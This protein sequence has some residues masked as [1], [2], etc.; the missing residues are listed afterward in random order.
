M[1]SVAMPRG[2][3]FIAVAN[4][5]DI[6]NSPNGDLVT[7]VLQ[8]C[9]NARVGQFGARRIYNIANNLFPGHKIPMRIF[10]DFVAECI[11]CQ[12]YR[13]GLVDNLEPVI[14]HLK[15]EGNRNVIGMDT[16]SLWKDKAGNAYLDVVVNH[17][18]K[19]VKLYPKPLVF[20][21]FLL[22]KYSNVAEDLFVAA[23]DS[24]RLMSVYERKDVLHTEPAGQ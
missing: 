12:K 22:D 11:I 7:R 20:S 2:T 19:L 17:F 14:R 24:I 8:A 16:L 13:I 15:P 23:F 6:L 3:D 4:A 5:N 1:G 9:H 18:T 10:R 21:A